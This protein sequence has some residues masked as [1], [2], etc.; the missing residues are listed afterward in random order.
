MNDMDYL[1]YTRFDG[2]MHFFTLLGD[3]RQ[4]DKK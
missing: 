3:L 2:G 1:W 4:T